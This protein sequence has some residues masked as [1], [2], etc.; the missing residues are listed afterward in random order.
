MINS[1]FLVGSLEPFA[2]DF[3]CRAHVLRFSHLCEGR[4]KDEAAGTLIDFD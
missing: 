3:I 2:V 4:G 1:F